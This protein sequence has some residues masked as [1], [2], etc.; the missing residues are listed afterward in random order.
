MALRALV[1][2]GAEVKRVIVT[3]HAAFGWRVLVLIVYVALHAV[4]LE[5]AFVEWP[6]S[7]EP[8]DALNALGADAFRA[9]HLVAFEARLLG[10]AIRPHH[11][12]ALRLVGEVV[13][14]NVLVL[15]A[16]HA[17]LALI[18]RPTHV[19]ELIR[20][21][22]LVTLAARRIG[23]LASKG[24]LGALGVVKAVG[25]PRRFW[26]AILA[27]RW[28]TKLFK[29]LFVWVVAGVAVCAGCAWGL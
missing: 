14:M 29:A 8:V 26:V 18:G 25:L 22:A 11:L 21:L 27:G 12:D 17:Q 20:P 3:A 19:E 15:V 9:F 23:V 4:D 24:K 10:L 5:M 13:V 6:G 2:E 16:A 7:A 28:T 1:A